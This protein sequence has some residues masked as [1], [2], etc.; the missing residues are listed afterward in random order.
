MF[1]MD[2][3]LEKRM[4]LAEAMTRV[5]KVENVSLVEDVE[6]DIDGAYG[7]AIDSSKVDELIKPPSDFSSSV[8]THVDVV[9]AE[10]MTE[11]ERIESG[12][13]SS[14]EIVHKVFNFTSSDTNITNFCS[15]CC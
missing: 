15:T 5:E 7:D 9:S 12:C 8:V 2:E 6:D 11:E 3:E 14:D 13:V 4:K 10:E 1:T